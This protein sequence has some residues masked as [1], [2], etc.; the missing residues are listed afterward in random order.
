MPRPSAPT[1]FATAKTHLEEALAKDDQ[2]APAHGVLALVLNNLGDHQGAVAAADRALELREG[3]PNALQ[4]R[5]DAY[6]A[7]GDEAK[8]TEAG[9]ALAAS[10]QNAETAKV[11]YNEGVEFSRTGDRE[12]AI[13]AFEEA[14]RLDPN[15]HEASD[16]LSGLYFRRR[17]L[18]R[19]G[20]RR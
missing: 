4:A 5:Y 12:A 2:L 9:E 3:E 16:A 6:R 15:L 19:L 11:V 20:G 8:A 17:P 10:G 1:D 7:L 18:R 14:G 13:K